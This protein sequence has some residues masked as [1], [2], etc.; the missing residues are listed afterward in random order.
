[1]GV[2]CECK[3]VVLHLKTLMSPDLESSDFEWD[4]DKNQRAAVDQCTKIRSLLKYCWYTGC[5]KQLWNQLRNKLPCHRYDCLIKR[6]RQY[7]LLGLMQRAKTIL[8]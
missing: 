5:P 6:Q 4:C 7:C 1:M 3:Y 2:R 8:G